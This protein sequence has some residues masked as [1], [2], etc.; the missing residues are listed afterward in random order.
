MPQG[1]DFEDF[2]AVDEEIITTQE[3]T[4]DDI[5]RIGYRV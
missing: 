5:V 3:M 1:V 2:V 4:D